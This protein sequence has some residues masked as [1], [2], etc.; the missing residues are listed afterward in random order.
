LRWAARE[1]HV[2]LAKLLIDR[3]ADKTLRD[4]EGRTPR[5]MAEVMKNTDVARLLE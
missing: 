1:G 3:G 5:E 4:K 2:G